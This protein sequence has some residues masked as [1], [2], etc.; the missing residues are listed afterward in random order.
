VTV[1]ESPAPERE[2]SRFRLIVLMPLAAIALTTF[3]VFVRFP[4][5]RLA[6]TLSQQIEASSGI[7]LEIGEF[8]P[9]LFLLG[10]GLLIRDAQAEWG[11]GKAAQIHE[12]AVRP[13]WSLKWLFASPALFVRVESPRGRGEGIVAFGWR[14]GWS[15]SLEAVDLDLVP[16][17]AL[18][19][20]F[21]VDGVLTADVD[22]HETGAD[23]GQPSLEGA[24]S[25]EVT[26]GSASVPRFP[27][28]LPFDVLKGELV[29][30]GEY[31]AQ[32]SSLELHG[33]MVR[34]DVE[35]SVGIADA[36]GNEPL[37]LDVTIEVKDDSL[38]T[39]FR[40][41]GVR[42]ERDGTT[43]FQIGGTLSHPRRS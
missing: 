25:F 24:L 17:D 23:E 20:E 2:Q 29:F 6:D 15:G 40:R 38:K 4:Y 36:P 33:P 41:A 32:V 7:K 18:V 42:L 10:P 43:S 14:G 12:I 28:A 21:D 19:A 34:A 16:L 13:A 39:M 31:V 26:D 27:V 5:D 3:F 35:G 22:L 1:I 30:G 11:R 8:S 9:H 37:A